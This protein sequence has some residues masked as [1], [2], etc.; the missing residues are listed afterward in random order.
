MKK[1]FSDIPTGINNSSTNV[2]TTNS[3]TIMQSS[4]LPVSYNL[5]QV[6]INCSESILHHQSSN[7]FTT[8]SSPLKSS[9]L[10]LSHNDLITSG[11]N[12]QQHHIDNLTTTNSTT[13]LAVDVVGNSNN[14]ECFD[15]TNNKDSKTTTCINKS[16]QLPLTKF[17]TPVLKKNEN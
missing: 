15:L 4:R 7:L 5:Q 8:S 3:T 1:S 16:K 9:S 10:L 17:F 2:N 11:I 14:K 13:L 6:P 12:Q